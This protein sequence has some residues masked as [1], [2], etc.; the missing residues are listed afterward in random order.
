[1]A[2]AKFFKEDFVTLI[3]N[4]SVFTRS[5]SGLA[6][7]RPTSLTWQVKAP[8]VSVVPGPAPSLC[9]WQQPLIAVRSHLSPGANPVCLDY[10]T[11]PPNSRVRF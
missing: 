11:P 4:P 2:I 6:M 9:P 5:P 7:P 1:M 3:L 10:I 8:Q